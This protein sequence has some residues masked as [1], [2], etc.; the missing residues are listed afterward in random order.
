MSNTL[1]L[2]SYLLIAFLLTFVLIPPYIRLL[3]RYRLGKKIR[4][5]GLIGKAVEFA[6]LHAGKI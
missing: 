4:E 2:L 6:K 3:Y 1:F 5:E